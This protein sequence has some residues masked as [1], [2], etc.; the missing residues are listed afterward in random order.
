MQV[1]LYAT[2]RLLAGIKS[3]EITLP[4]RISALQVLDEITRRYPVLQPHWFGPDHCLYPH[5]HV[6]INGEDVMNLPEG[7]HTLLASADTVEI[8]PPVA[9]G[10]A[11]LTVQ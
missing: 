3:L 2:F 6:L 7:I 4:E 11:Q 8:F 1:N 9:G 10:T 5:V